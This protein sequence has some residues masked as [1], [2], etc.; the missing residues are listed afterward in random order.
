MLRKSLPPDE[1]L[2]VLVTL[3]K[4]Y[5]APMMAMSLMAFTF[6]TVVEERI[7]CKSERMIGY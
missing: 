7:I 3:L 2:A 4:V 1:H 6:S 5:F